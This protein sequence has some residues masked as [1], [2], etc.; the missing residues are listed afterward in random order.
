MSTPTPTERLRQAEATVNTIRRELGLPEIPA[1]DHPTTI[2]AHTLR[3][4]T[5]PA[6]FNISRPSRLREEY[7]VTVRSPANTSG[8]YPELGDCGQIAIPRAVLLEMVR[9]V[10][11]EL[12]ATTPL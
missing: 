2:F 11:R 4:A 9:E 8:D 6:Y 10:A 7:L 3:G 12:V 5:Y 1:A